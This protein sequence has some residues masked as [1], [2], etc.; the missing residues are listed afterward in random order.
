MS[1]VSRFPSPEAMEQYLALGM[2]E[3]ITQAV[4]QIDA[5]LAVGVAS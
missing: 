1:I 4:G 5:I 3:G 2:E